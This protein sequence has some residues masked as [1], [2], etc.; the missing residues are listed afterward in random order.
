[1]TQTYIDDQ[2]LIVSISERHE[3][4]Q[5]QCNEYSSQV[6]RSSRCTIKWMF[7]I[8]ET[9]CQIYREATSSEQTMHGLGHTI[10]LD[11]A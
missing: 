4:V 11:D 10:L 8:D 5:N 1:M 7:A 2:G 9:L 3:C 6:S